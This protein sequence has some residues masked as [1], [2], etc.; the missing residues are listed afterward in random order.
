MESQSKPKNPFIFLTIALGMS[1]VMYF[2]A[3]HSER[4][5]ADELQKKL[6][7]CNGQK[8]HTSPEK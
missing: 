8:V 2:F 7:L 1:A 3:F 5:R 4:D 6:E